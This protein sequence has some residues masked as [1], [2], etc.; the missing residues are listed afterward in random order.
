MT[1]REMLIHDLQNFKGEYEDC[2]TDFF[3]CPYSTDKDCHN[4]DTEYGTFGFEENCHLCKLE[5]LEK[6]WKE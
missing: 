1:N 5:W 6:E 2:V 3:S 4:N